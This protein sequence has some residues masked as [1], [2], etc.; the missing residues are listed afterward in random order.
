MSSLA[1]QVMDL[2]ASGSSFPIVQSPGTPTPVKDAPASAPVPST[3]AAVA[4][5][6]LSGA[7]L[8][9][10]I[11]NQWATPANIALIIQIILGVNYGL[12]LFYGVNTS[13]IALLE[14]VVTIY[15]L[16]VTIMTLL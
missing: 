10:A 11:T 2:I 13:L 6:P 7:A 1:S 16:Y 9:T 5:A 15:F 14:T 3:T 4:A 8:A 12:T